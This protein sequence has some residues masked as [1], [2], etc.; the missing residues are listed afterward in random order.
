MAVILENVP[1]LMDKPKPK[2]KVE[3][4]GQQ[5][6]VEEFKSN[7]DAVKSELNA[8]GFRFVFLLL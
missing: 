7:F 3:A 5:L 4:D 1:T 8:R 2:A 6:S